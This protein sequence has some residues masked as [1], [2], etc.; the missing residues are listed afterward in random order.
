[1]E[2]TDPHAPAL[3]AA[4]EEPPRLPS[5]FVPYDWDQAREDFLSGEPAVI[6]GARLQ[7]SERTVQR[8]AAQEGWRRSD[9]AR[10]AVTP[11]LDPTL[12]VHGPLDGLMLASEIERRELLDHPDPRRS[13]RFAYMRANEAAVRGRPSEALSWA[14]LIKVLDRVGGSV[15][16]ACGLSS[17]A[18]FLRAIDREA[19]YARVAG[20]AWEEAEL[21]AA[22]LEDEER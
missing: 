8:R 11:P 15:R 6:V 12:S 16:M 5:T 9:H 1:M 4:K 3:P 14:R 13:I 2:K 20:Q 17:D 18:D 10:C 22:D 19:R 7:V 21:D